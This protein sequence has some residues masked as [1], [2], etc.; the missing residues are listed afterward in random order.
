MRF[1]RKAWWFSNFM[2]PFNIHG[3][4]K[5]LLIKKKIFSSN[6]WKRKLLYQNVC[7]L[8]CYSTTQLAIC[9]APVS[10]SLL[11]PNNYL[12]ITFLIATKVNYFQSLLFFCPF[13]IFHSLS[14]CDIICSYILSGLKLFML[15]TSIFLSPIK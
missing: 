14:C 1:L 9:V 5:Y 13:S 4:F 3:S 10:S 11:F 8:L 6:P 12:P 15:T 7:F 2:C